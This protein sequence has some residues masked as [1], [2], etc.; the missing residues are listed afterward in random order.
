MA[1]DEGSWEALQ[2]YRKSKGEEIPMRI[3][4]YWLVKPGRSEGENIAQVERAV[5]LARLFNADT[6]PDCRVVGVKVIC[7]G[8][9]DACTAGLT[10]PYAHN[11]HMEVPLW[12]HEELEPVV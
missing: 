9:I 11:E 2:A 4:A 6:T 10:E 8:I 12:T 5:E 3:A 1:M 7:D